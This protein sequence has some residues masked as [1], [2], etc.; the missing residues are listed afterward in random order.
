MAATNRTYAISHLHSGGLITNYYCTSACGHCLY[1]CSPHWSKQY[2]D[3]AN[4]DKNLRIIRRLGCRSIHVGGG[5]PFLHVEGLQMVIETSHSL[6]VQVDYVETNS[7]WY[8]DRDTACQLLSSLKR[9]GLSTL[10]ISM[11][12]FH[13]EHI[14]FFKVKGVVEACHDTGIKVFPWISDFFPEITALGDKTTHRLSEYESRYGIDYLRKIRSRYWI[15]LGGRALKTFADVLNSE[16]Y[17]TFLTED[18]GG[19]Q[20]LFDV[21]HF[22]LDLFGNYIPGLCSGL[23][24]D[25]DDLGHPI[26]S[27]KYPFLYVLFDRGVKG[28]FERVVETYDFKLADRYLSK[29]HLCFDLRRYLVLKEGLKTRDLQPRSFYDNI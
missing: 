21:S 25:R 5:E 23:A 9:V 15:H 27:E 11:S 4:T 6:D 2:I 3:I 10:L 7:S 20:E 26:S 8:R 13:N 12:P 24:M 18:N 14:P 19:C 22:H 17:E 16:P 28:L 1:G 29:C